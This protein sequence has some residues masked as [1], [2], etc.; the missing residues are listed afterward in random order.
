MSRATLCVMLALAAGLAGG[1]ATTRT[2]SRIPMPRPITPPS[3]KAI[4]TSI[5]RGLTF[6]LA[7]Q[8]A[9]GS[10]G[11]PTQT[12][13]LNIYAPVPGAHRS[14]HAAVTAMCISALC[15]VDDGQPATKRAIDR[16]EQWLLD[17]LGKVRRTVTT[18]YVVWA[19]A[20][21]IQALV[22]LRDRHRGETSERRRAIDQLVNQQIDLLHRYEYAGGGW[23]YYVSDLPTIRPHGYVNS[24][25]TATVMI[26]LREARH[27]GYKVPQDMVT[28]G[29]H[30]LHEQ[31]KPNFTYLYSDDF[32]YYTMRPINRAPG[33]LG[34]SQV[35]NAAL[36]MWGDPAI[37][38]D[39]LHAWLNRLF[40]EN[41]WLSNGRKRPVPHEAPFQVAG[42]FY[43][44]GHYYAGYCIDMLPQPQRRR[45]ADYLAHTLMSHQE[46]DGSWWD[47]P[48]YNYHQQ[49]GTAFALMS[50]SR[51][52]HEHPETAVD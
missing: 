28:R 19:N 31:Q 24:F 49:Y 30:V 48:L 2:G 46:A 3:A 18:L 37:T 51:C 26:A 7:A 47:F 40:A 45:Y 8:N 16:G 25:T 9:D 32:N 12:K 14:Y 34:R 20:Y 15:A 50:L 1:C 10:W 17:H 43:Y 44:Y 13:D 29:L 35:C 33:S 27:A 39:V 41:G 23:G 36:R 42:Y 11:S 52:R 38:N 4:D 21:G 22:T 6:L 5:A